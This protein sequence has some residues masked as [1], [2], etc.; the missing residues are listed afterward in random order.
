MQ[1]A[2][3]NLLSSNDCF[4]TPDFVGCSDFASDSSDP[5]DGKHC[6]PVR[7]V[8][9]HN[10]GKIFHM[11]HDQHTELNDRLTSRSSPTKLSV[12]AISADWFTPRLLISR[13]TR[14]LP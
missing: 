3:R 9:P 12:P 14:V 5:A 6:F 10:L 8:V 7:K 4:E 2:G 1:L 11:G 13:R